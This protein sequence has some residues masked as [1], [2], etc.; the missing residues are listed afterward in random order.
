MGQY[1][2][3]SP[4][5]QRYLVNAPDGATDEA[6]FA[7]AQ[8][9]V[10]AGGP[11]VNA[12]EMLLQNKTP[13]QFGSVDPNLQV[14]ESLDR[15]KFEASVPGR[16]LR[17]IEAPALKLAEVLPEHTLTKPYID[18][19][20]AIQDYRQAGRELQSETEQRAGNAAGAAGSLIPSIAVGSGI[21]RLGYAGKGIAQALSRIAANAAAGGTV[22]GMQPGSTMR[23]VETGAAF[24]GALT[25]L[26]EVGRG[27]KNFM[28]NRLGPKSVTE[29]WLQRH[30]GK[31]YIDKAAE[32]ARTPA[33]VKDYP[34]TAAEKMVGAP[35]RGAETSQEPAGTVIQALQKQVEA[36]PGGIS[37]D[38]MTQ[39]L[40]Q[41]KALESAKN[42]VE[43]ATAPLRTQAFAAIREKG[44]VPTSKLLGEI[45]DLGQSPRIASKPAQNAIENIR[46]VIMEKQGRSLKVDPEFLHSL[47]KDLG[48]DIGQT[49]GNDKAKPSKE[50]IAFIERGIQ[51]SIDNA[52]E[53][54]GGNT[55]KQYLT[56]YSKR[57]TPINNVT[58]A[59][60]L[61]Y[62]PAVKTSLGG[63][64]EGESL[65]HILPDFL[66]RPVTGTKWLSKLYAPSM[67][68]KIDTYLSEI[69]RNPAQLADVIESPVHPYNKIAGAL[70][71][72]GITTGVTGA[73]GG[74]P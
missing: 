2:L 35:L 43:T 65:S 64:M 58:D 25:G 55:W 31:D 37:S 10:M 49:W 33:P 23:D 52:M 17:G 50:T 6:I 62:K 53:R 11:S 60:L 67:E 39:R 57:M 29:N 72:R 44:G 74:K 73:Y 38:F 4:D 26:Y 24:G 20:Q 15:A 28:Q 3:T 7:Y 56:D 47:R 14:G 66:S 19:V 22:A 69:L 30:I 54:A 8:N 1:R 13:S 42:A 40:A 70:L 51:K 34:A 46:N 63:K 61:Q 41:T 12:P 32:L 9:Q 36:K 27:T 59:L 45:Y 71:N 18:Y 5:G 68:R 21:G 48:Y 16:L